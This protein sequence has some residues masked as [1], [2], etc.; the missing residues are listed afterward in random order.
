VCM[1]VCRFCVVPITLFVAN[2]SVD[3]SFTVRYETVKADDQKQVTPMLA[4]GNQASV[5]EQEEALMILMHDTCC[6][7]CCY[8]CC[9]LIERAS[10]STCGV[11]QPIR[12]LEHWHH[13]NRPK[14]HRMCASSNLVSMTLIAS[15]LLSMPAHHRSNIS[16]RH[17]N[18]LFK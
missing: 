18:T 16:T 1:W 17:S 6:S 2:T 12:T 5:R 11:E 9:C 14:S 13:N 10:G 8:C 7:W 4:Y 15:S 3:I